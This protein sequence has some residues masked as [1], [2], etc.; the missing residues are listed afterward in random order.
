MTKSDYLERRMLV[1]YKA[2]S[3]TYVGRFLSW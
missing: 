1:L 2:S 3:A